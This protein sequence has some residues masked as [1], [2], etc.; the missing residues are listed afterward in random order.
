MKID[1]KK[2]IL[3]LLLLRN[4]DFGCFFFLGSGKIIY[5]S[6]NN[7]R[8]KVKLILLILYYPNVQ[9]GPFHRTS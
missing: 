9:V 3:L 7:P 2:K 6:L 8:N 5:W 4:I 1:K